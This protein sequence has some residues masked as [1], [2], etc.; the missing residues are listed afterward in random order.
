MRTTA[1]TIAVA[2]VGVALA[3]CSGSQ[4]TK[5]AHVDALTRPALPKWISEISP[6]TTAASL[7]QIRVIFASPV[8]PVTSL[9]GDGPRA[10]LD[11]FQIEP[12]LPGRFVL[13]TPRMVGFVGDRALPIGMRVRVTL[14]AGLR[15][16]A[17]DALGSDLRWT[18]DT[19]PLDFS[20]LPQATASPGEATPAPASL[21]PKIDIVANAG[22]DV[23]TLTARTT[24]RSDDGKTIALD[25][26]LAPTPSAAPSQPPDAGAAFDASQQTLTYELTPRRR[27][28]PSTTYTL[29][30]A[31]GVETTAGNVS[32]AKAFHGSLRTYDP[33]TIQPSPTPD[34]RN[35]PNGVRFALGDP[36]IAFNNAID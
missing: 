24:L 12:A 27:L 32:T 1:C 26:A 3:A 9:E 25:A 23:A 17:G 5:P 15:D 35:L 11:H 30:I 16:L 4:P 8:A 10:V 34:P 18:F 21:Q 7:S 19:Q 22:V 14:S 29:A 20:E 28:A 6:T 2:V 33:L 36:V 13:F 31:P